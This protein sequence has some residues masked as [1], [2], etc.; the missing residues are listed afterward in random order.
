[1]TVKQKF[2]AMLRAA[3]AE[4]R[5]TWEEVS[6]ATNIP[7]ASLKTYASGATCPPLDKAVAIAKFFAINLDG[8]M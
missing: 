8:L 3:R 5:M 1:M 6:K 2:A 7:E 4:H